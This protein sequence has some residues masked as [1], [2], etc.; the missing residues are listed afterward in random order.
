[1]L[2]V[3]AMT[4][5]RNYGIWVIVVGSVLLGLLVILPAYM[6]IRRRFGVVPTA[7]AI[8]MQQEEEL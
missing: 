7:T 1:V 3:D 2:P 4:T 6:Y 8:R 5:V